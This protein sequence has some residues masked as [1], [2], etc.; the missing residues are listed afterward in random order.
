MIAP[1]A[2]AVL[3]TET[4]TGAA[5]LSRNARRRRPVASLTK[6]M[7]ALLT[8]EN[9]EIDA[10]ICVSD[11]AASV[12]EATAYL[13]AGEILSVRELL[14]VM[15]VRSANDAANALADEIV[16]WPD[17]ISAPGK[18]KSGATQIEKRFANLMNRRAKELGMFDTHYV[19][20]DGLDAP[21]H[22]SSARDSL[23]LARTIM[24]K[25][26]WRAFAGLL[27]AE[28]PGGRKFHTTHDLLPQYGGMVGGKFGYTDEAGYCLSG[29]ARRDGVELYGVVLGCPS[30]DSRTSDLKAALDYGFDKFKGTVIA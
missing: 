27:T 5:L 17:H 19:R 16:F 7:T 4:V 24:E 20:S 15:L 10:A 23:I 29:V 26:E 25:P 22:L 30:R 6:L 28:L 11:R 21:G 13:R 12:G 1:E 3:V 8:L 18:A 14:S 9:M 2:K